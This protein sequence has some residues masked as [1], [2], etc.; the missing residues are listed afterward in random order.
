[1]KQNITSYLRYFGINQD[2]L[3]EM[4]RQELMETGE[5]EVYFDGH[6]GI[7]AMPINQYKTVPTL[8]AH[9]DTICDHRATGYDNYA[10]TIRDGYLELS[11]SAKEVEYIPYVS[12]FTQN[13]TWRSTPKTQCLG[14]DDRSGVA[15]VMG[16]LYQLLSEGR[17]DLPIIMFCRDEEIG[18]HTSDLT[19]AI[20]Q[21]GLEIDTNLLIEVDTPNWQTTTF[22]EFGFGSREGDPRLKKMLERFGY[23]QHTGTAVT[24][25]T[26]IGKDLNLPSISVSASYEH[27]HTPQERLNMKKWS[28]NFDRLYQLY[29]KI[30]GKTFTFD[31]TWKYTGRTYGTT[32]GTQT[33][34]TASGEIYDFSSEFYDDSTF[35]DFDDRWNEKYW[36]DMDGDTVES[37]EEMFLEELITLV[38]IYALSEHKANHII[39]M[40]SEVLDI[41]S[42]GGKL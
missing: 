20:E 35:L 5:Y 30:D 8:I 26:G 39:A 14:A 1:M 11:E 2:T 3:D 33:Y 15:S 24:D 21:A 28:Q 32:A 27:E 41:K 7:V 13:T 6:S 18:G 34:R 4:L 42:K 31:Y 29:N 9:M 23:V 38:D 36:Q 10:I 25:I 37:E 22:R 12:Q 19:K 40:A 16:M 17:T